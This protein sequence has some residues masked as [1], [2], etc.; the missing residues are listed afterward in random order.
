MSSQSTSTEPGR[1]DRGRRRAHALDRRPSTAAVRTWTRG[2]RRSLA[3]FAL[4][5][6]APIG[7]ALGAVPARAVDWQKMVMPGPLAGAHAE[8]ESDCAS[9]HKAF[10]GGAERQLC[11]TC[12]EE[13][14]ADVAAKTG[15]HGRQTMALSGPCRSCHAEHKGRSADIL[16]LSEAT[17][18]H[19]RT[20]YPLAGAHQRVACDGCHVEGRRRDAAP[21]DCVG[22][23]REDDPHGDAMS[24]DCDS[25][26]D[27][28][29]W[30][31]TRFDHDRTDHPLTGAHREAACDGCHA[32]RRFEGT[33]TEC[34]ACHAID[35]AHGGRF[36]RAC[37][38][39]HTTTAWRRKDFDHGRKTGFPLEGA[40][41]TARCDSC[42]RKP[43]GELEL[44]K[45]CGAC[46]R[47]D[48]VH[49]GRFGTACESCHGAVAWKTVR[50]DHDRKTDFP[51]RDA[52]AKVACEG[53]HMRGLESDQ[54]MDMRCIACHAKDDVHREALGSDCAECH[55]ELRFAGR[56]RFD[57]DLTRFPLLGLHAVAG[58][59]ACHADRTFQRDDRACRA[60]HAGDDVHAGTLGSDCE[61]CHTPNG[62]MLWQF[63]HDAQT[64]FAL[65][66]GHAGIACDGCH[67]QP[68][69]GA[70]QMAQRCVDCHETEDAHRGR[71]GRGCQNCHSDAAWKPARIR[72]SGGR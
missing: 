53:C 27:E 57:H 44:P 43:P 47:A 24:D 4:L 9:C 29:R 21:Q 7:L 50:F 22:C 8:L 72:G 51:L 33:P 40:H 18:D 67:R 1:A 69:G 56:V 68:M 46:H 20:D 41:A 35:D 52:H 54:K 26:H 63:D 15:Y 38:D 30:Q 37:A 55:D 70:F 66:G 61:R 5:G 71:F 17:F 48:D 14:A 16:G 23:H 36:G 19:A 34:I 64:R 42:H 2:R 65:A 31:A 25:C 49:A 10:D 45:D 13:V 3:C 11:M 62:W 12:H 32:G 60:C 59:E 6:L 28:V 39:C 58:C